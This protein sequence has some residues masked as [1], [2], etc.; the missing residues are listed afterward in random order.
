LNENNH[1]LLYNERLDHGII[2]IQKTTLCCKEVFFMKQKRY[3]LGLILLG[4]SLLLFFRWLIF[5]K[6]VDVVF[7][8][9]WLGT[10]SFFFQLIYNHVEKVYLFVQKV[11]FNITNPDTLWNFVADFEHLNKEDLFEVKKVFTEHKDLKMVREINNSAFE[12]AFKNGIRVQIVATNSSEINLFNLHIE[13][14]DLQVTFRKSLDVIDNTISTM[15]EDIISIIS[16]KV[17]AQYHYV[18][19]FDNKRDI[20]PFYG[21]YISRVSK[22]DLNTFNIVF[23][24]D[25]SSVKVSKKR[26]TLSANSI[27]KVNQLTKKYLLLGS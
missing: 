26:I 5:V 21:L 24:K 3:L 15:M 17:N 12:I 22:S 18:I 14:Q 20:N 27:T 1:N 19:S 11:K 9:T 6:E 2:K 7:L 23:S 8:G 4:S 13:F 16:T 10:I 25:E